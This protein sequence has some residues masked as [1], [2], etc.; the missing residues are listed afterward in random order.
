M[1]D[2][3]CK[4]VK[5]GET[6]SAIS[7][8]MSLVFSNKDIPADVQVLCHDCHHHAMNLA[9]DMIKSN[10]RNYCD[11]LDKRKAFVLEEATRRK[12]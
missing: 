1:G 4:T 12:S 7:Y 8:D 2:Y 11:I 5:V 6:N 9:M 10:V 3:K